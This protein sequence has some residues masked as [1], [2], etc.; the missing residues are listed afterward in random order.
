M[1]YRLSVNEEIVLSNNGIDWDD[2]FGYTKDCKF[3]GESGYI[4]SYDEVM[5]ILNNNKQ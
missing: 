1:E 3:D 5:E 4:C 2:V